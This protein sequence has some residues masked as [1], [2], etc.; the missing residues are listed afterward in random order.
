MFDAV[1][2]FFVRNK[3]KVLASGAVTSAVA[4]F[5]SVG[6]FASSTSYTPKAIPTP[7]TMDLDTLGNVWNY[8]QS[9]F[10]DTLAIISNHPILV[11]ILIALPLVGIGV[12]LFK[13]II[14]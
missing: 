13:R 12:G 14:N 4:L 5:S 10:Q 1:R 7:Q 11:T 3:N 8:A 2:N 9:M 6:S